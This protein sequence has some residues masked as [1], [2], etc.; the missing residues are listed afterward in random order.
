MLRRLSFQTITSSKASLC[1]AMQKKLTSESTSTK[2]SVVAH[3][4]LH[5]YIPKGTE[6]T[7]I[8]T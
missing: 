1:K 4:D 7:N 3:K 2:K 8:H 6:G 5:M